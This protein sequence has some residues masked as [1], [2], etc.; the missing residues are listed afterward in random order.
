MTTTMRALAPAPDGRMQLVQ[1]PIPSPGP[2]RI[3]VEVK[4]SAVNEMDVQVRAGGWGPQVKRFRKTGPVVTG[5]E[6]AGVARSDGARIKVGD[7]VIG[8]VH[9][10]DGPRV[11]ADFAC[12]AEADMQ[13]IPPDL[14][15][16]DAAAL[17]VMGLTAIEILER[18][19]RLSVGQRCLV[20]GAAGGV[21]AYAVQL[22]RSQGASVG[23]VCS[24]ANAGWV[25]SLGAT[26][27]RPYESEPRYRPGDRFDLVI[28]CPAKFSFREAAP[29]LAKD[30]MYVT[31]NPLA[32]A[33]GFARAALT[34]RKAGYL[35]ML[36]TT[37][38]K[39]SR[40]V[41]LHGQ[42]ALRPVID[43]VFDME[44]ADAAFDR[45]ET[46]GKQGRVLLKISS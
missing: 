10:L 31:T 17:V 13:V 41:E 8:Y 26:E 35:M 5:F 15:D 27:I 43:G 6:F 39:L 12:V 21:G 4:V 34:S 25:E 40:L 42:G 20:I 29:C 24:S 44:D 23:A 46:R 30:G 33:A 19:K 7:R 11:H 2:G 9:V 18:L 1:V 16:E 28:D 22:A 3:F 32:D 36:T 38:A 45:F 14:N 37:P